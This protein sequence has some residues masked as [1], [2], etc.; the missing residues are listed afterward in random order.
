[1]LHAASRTFANL[2]TSSNQSFRT[3]NKHELAVMLREA[4]DYTL[5]LFACFVQSGADDLLG[6]F[7]QCPVNPP[8]WELGHLA[9]FAEL[10]VLRQPSANTQNG[11]RLP[12]M[13]RKADAW[14]DEVIL[15]ENARVILDLPK[16]TQLITYKNE[17]LDRVLD[18]LS[19]VDE[20][21]DAAA[22]A[23]ALRPFRQAL[24]YEDSIGEI[25]VNLL[26]T[27]GLRAP[28]WIERATAAPWSREEIRFAGGSFTMGV[29]DEEARRGFAF[30]HERGAHQVKVASFH[31]DANLVSNAQ[32]AEFVADNGYQHAQHWSPNG[33]AWLMQQERSAPLHWEKSGTWW[34]T[35]RFGRVINLSPNEPVRHVNLFEVQAYCL[36]ANRRL[37]SEQEW[38]YAAMAGHPLFHW[39]DCW[40]WTWSIFEPYPEFVADDS[41]VG[42]ARRASTEAAFGQCQSVR[43][44][45][46][47]TPQ[48]AR[49][50]R[51]RHFLMPDQ[52][53]F[54]A[55]FRTCA[56]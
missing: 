23:A 26:Q 44:A 48:R 12:A 50:G 28:L 6:F 32:F 43:G 34:R 7:E 35:E 5:S 24:A 36:W 40:E 31:M 22:T 25:W 18:R 17:V 30:Q 53:D 13:L 3:A 2:M 20:N 21:G 42:A 11:Q 37:P 9:W 10:A 14:F 51:F 46:F 8:V 54:V 33:I 16:A 41:A 15:S 56:L 1:M 29:Q 55:G 19:R 27:L 4:H 45:S 47:V 38:E 52:C 49:D 39:G